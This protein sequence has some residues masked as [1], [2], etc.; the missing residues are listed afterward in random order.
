MRLPVW[1]SYHSGVPNVNT[2]PLPADADPSAEVMSLMRR[3][4][5]ER[6]QGARHRFEPGSPRAFG[7]LGLRALG[8]HRPGRARPGYAA[9]LL[10]RVLEVLRARG[11]RDARLFTQ[12]YRR[13][14][15][16]AY[17]RLGF[18]PVYT[19]EGHIQQALWS[20]IFQTLD[21]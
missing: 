1:A 7:H 4:H 17:L 8:C 10:L 21:G 2:D 12:P 9:A 5:L 18:L 6:R 16:R 19:V 14:A 11:Y 20:M 3:P 15:I 13:P